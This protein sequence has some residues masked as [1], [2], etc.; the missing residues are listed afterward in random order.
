MTAGV[1]TYKLLETVEPL[2]DRHVRTGELGAVRKTIERI[3]ASG[4]EF[5]SLHTAD[6]LVTA[7]GRPDL[8]YTDLKP[9]AQRNAKEVDAPMPK[10]KQR[11]PVPD[12]IPSKRCPGALCQGQRLPLSPEFWSFYRSGNQAGQPRGYCRECDSFKTGQY[13]KERRLRDPEGYRK[14][15]QASEIRKRKH[16][17]WQHCGLV[18]VAKVWFA[19]DELCRILGTEGVAQ[20]VG[21]HRATVFEW[22]SRRFS[23]VRKEHA[24]RIL[25][26][27]W[28]VRNGNNSNTA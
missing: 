28:E 26:A 23:T 12:D 25:Q 22:R 4:E 18:P 24:A 27:L 13:R 17:E 21:V 10:R 3:K 7:V 11:S 5:V 15:R 9:V 20:R 19:I 14:S 6:R 1:S 2:I 16:R 8:L